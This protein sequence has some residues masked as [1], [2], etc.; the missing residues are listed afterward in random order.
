MQVKKD[1]TYSVIDY[2]LIELK[3]G[4]T[5]CKALMKKGRYI[6]KQYYR[7][8]MGYILSLNNIINNIK[9]DILHNILH[10]YEVHKCLSII[11]AAIHNLLI[12]A[13]QRKNHPIKYFNYSSFPTYSFAEAHPTYAIEIGDLEK[14]NFYYHRVLENIYNKFKTGPPILCLSDRSRYAF[15][16]PSKIHGEKELDT[17]YFLSPEEINENYIKNQG[18]PSSIINKYRL[19][20]YL[21]HIHYPRSAPRNLR[22]APFL[23]HEHFHRLI[24]LINSCIILCISLLDNAGIKKVTPEILLKLESVFGKNIVKLALLFFELQE[25]YQKDVANQYYAS[26][27]RVYLDRMERHFVELICDLGGIFLSGPS[28]FYAFISYLYGEE[29]YNNIPNIFSSEVWDRDD[30][31]PPPSIRLHF[32]LSIL[33]HFKYDSISDNIQRQCIDEFNKYKSKSKYNLLYCEWLNNNSNKIKEFVKCLK[34]F[35]DLKYGNINYSNS[36]IISMVDSN[37]TSMRIT[38]IQVLNAIWYKK[39]NNKDLPL[40]EIRWRLVL[41]NSIT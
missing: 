17:R 11:P 38:P 21:S 5:M 18:K 24:R 20:L 39:I 1:F 14:I 41:K 36:K 16:L 40:W 13:L 37:I 10:Q 29:F 7:S 22:Y 12:F 2:Y 32:M 9:K 8:M 31:H 19:W 15:E 30:D 26:F 25:T 28:F 23:A 27:S 33:E 35:S 4:E 3:H 34:K 6:D